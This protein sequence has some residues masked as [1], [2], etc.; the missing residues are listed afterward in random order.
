MLTGLTVL[1]IPCCFVDD[2]NVMLSESEMK[3]KPIYGDDDS[4][5]FQRYCAG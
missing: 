4:Q 5:A 1:G 3:G 2:Y